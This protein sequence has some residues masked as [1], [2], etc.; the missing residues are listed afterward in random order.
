MR[1]GIVG[2]GEI[3]RKLYLPLLLNRPD[4]DV[5]GV[6]SRSPDNVAQV[7]RQYRIS[8]LFTDL[9][10]L[11]A[12]RPDLVFVHAATAAHHELVSACLETGASAYVDK[13]LASNLADCEDLVRRADRA[14][15]L[16]A[17]GFNRRFAPMYVRARD[18]LSGG[19]RFA[20]MEKHRA[21]LHDQTT[22][23]AVFDDLIHVLDT[24][25]WLLGE[26]V[27]L[28]ASDIRLDPTGW[29]TLAVGTVQS[30][31]ATGSYAMARAVGADTERLGLHGSGRSAEVVDLE[32]CVLDDRTD[33]R[34]VITFGSWDT[35]AERRGFNALVQHVLDTVDRPDDCE[36]SGAQVL[37]THR[38][39][40]SIVESAASS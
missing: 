14:S 11:L 26:R 15:R 7:G 24:M 23:Q 18:W 22:R 12:A 38:L 9:D 10:E 29:L 2:L 37:A 5:V 25:C 39:A 33:G 13:P 28:A 1:I 36:V 30:P 19:L 6:M 21:A 8:N 34:R 35:V 4:V 16:L 20:V 31:D 40:E 17:V 27:E 32:Q 3:A